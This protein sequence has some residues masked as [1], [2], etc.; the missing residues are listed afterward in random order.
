MFEEALGLAD[1]FEPV[2]GAATCAEL[3]AKTHLRWGDRR[4]EQARGER[5]S[6]SAAMAKEGRLH[7]RSAGRAFEELGRIRFAAREFSGDLW[8]A[9]D[10]YFRGQS[11]TNAA[12]VFEEYLHHEARKMERHGAAQAWSISAGRHRSTGRH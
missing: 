12:R 4:L 1:L 6:E 3:R 8:T 11:Y 2:V 10:C 7:L 9:G 5:G